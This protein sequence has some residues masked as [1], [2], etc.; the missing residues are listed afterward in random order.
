MRINFFPRVKKGDPVCRFC[1][2]LFFRRVRNILEDIQGIGCRI[3]KKQDAEGNGWRIVVD[4]SSDVPLPPDFPPEERRNYPYGSTRW[5]W[6]VDIISTTAGDIINMAPGN[7]MGEAIAETI[8]Y[9]TYSTVLRET[10]V[11]GLGGGVLTA[12]QNFVIAHV[13][14]SSHNI[15]LSLEEY[16]HDEIR[17]QYAV[18]KDMYRTIHRIDSVD[19]DGVRRVTQ[20]VPY[21]FGPIR[22]T[23]PLLPPGTAAWPN[24]RW[25]SDDGIWMPVA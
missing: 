11:Y 22:A 15:T 6:G 5:L 24:L 21:Q 12:G 14:F 19:V 9:G 23:F 10:T 2:I 25:N 16:Q 1:D 20:I 4:G 8:N 17:E 3:I 13:D 18:V 7:S